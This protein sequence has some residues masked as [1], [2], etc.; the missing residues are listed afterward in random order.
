MLK[1]SLFLANAMGVYCATFDWVTGSGKS[2]KLTTSPGPYDGCSGYDL[3]TLQ[4]AVDGSEA[5]PVGKSFDFNAPDGPPYEFTIDMN[6]P[7]TF[8]EWRLKEPGDCY[9]FKNVKLQYQQGSSFVDVPGSALLFSSSTDYT[10]FL[11]AKFTKS[12]TAQVWRLY[13]ADKVRE[14][15]DSCAFQ[16]CSASSFVSDSCAR[17]AP[18]LGHPF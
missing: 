7:A 4:Y 9:S 8:D 13:G 17:G 3:C 14:D 5:D 18:A 2:W 15:A 1:L 16:V 11:N 10:Q 12:V 6:S